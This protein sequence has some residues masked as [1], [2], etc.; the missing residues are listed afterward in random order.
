MDVGL[1]RHLRKYQRHYQT[2]ESQEVIISSLDQK[3]SP[4]IL[5]LWT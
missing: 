3:G 1:E 5:D 4:S 2:S